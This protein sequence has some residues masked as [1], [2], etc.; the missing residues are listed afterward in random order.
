[1]E[2]EASEAGLRFTEREG[3]SEWTW[4]HLRKDKPT[5]SLRGPWWIPEYLPIK[6]SLYSGKEISTTRYSNFLAGY[7]VAKLMHI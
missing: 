7:R 2:H 5:R 1:M 6:W 4:D 3:V